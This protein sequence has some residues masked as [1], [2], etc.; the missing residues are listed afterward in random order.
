MNEK[1][2]I[3]PNTEKTEMLKLSNKNFKEAMI[4]RKKCFKE[5]LQNKYKASTKK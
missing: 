5:Q 4:K 2:S 3:D 1:N